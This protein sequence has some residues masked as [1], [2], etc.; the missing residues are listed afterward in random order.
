MPLKRTAELNALRELRFFAALLLEAGD[1]LA[2]L[3]R[4]LW[5]RASQLTSWLLVALV[6]RSVGLVRQGMRGAG[7]GGGHAAAKAGAARRQRRQGAAGDGL[8]GWSPA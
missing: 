8:G 3:L 7:L 4:T 2:P 6:G 1:L 5:R